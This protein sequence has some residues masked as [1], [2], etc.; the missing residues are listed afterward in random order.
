ML[1]GYILKQKAY[2]YSNIPSLVVTVKLKMNSS[3]HLWKSNLH[4]SFFIAFYFCKL[5]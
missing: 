1:H 4:M 3:Y 5:L 2:Y